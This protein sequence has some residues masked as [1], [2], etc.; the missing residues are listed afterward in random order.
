MNR[1]RDRFIS[2][3]PLTPYK[4]GEVEIVNLSEVAPRFRK[5]ALKE[6]LVWRD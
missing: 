1:N 2:H 5:E 3:L 6:A 4:G